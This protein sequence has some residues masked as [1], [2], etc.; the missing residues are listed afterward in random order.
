M[1]TS[2]NHHGE[3]KKPVIKE[4]IHDLLYE[5]LEKSKLINVQW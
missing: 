3:Q 2:Q 5:V 1:D 4:N